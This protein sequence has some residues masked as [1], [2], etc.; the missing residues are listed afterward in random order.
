MSLFNIFFKRKEDIQPEKKSYS[1]HSLIEIL[2][3]KNDE[4]EKSFTSLAMERHN[5]V[6]S[7]IDSIKSKLEVFDNHK[8]GTEEIDPRLLQILLGN[9]KILSTRLH[10]ICATL[11][12]D[13]GEETDSIIRYYKSSHSNLVKTI[14]DT[15][16]NYKKIEYHFHKMIDPVLKDI[17]K[18]A[19]IL[20]SFQND[21][22]NFQRKKQE[23][24]SLENSVKELE[25]TISEKNNISEKKSIMGERLQTLEKEK[26]DTENRLKSLVS[27]G[28]Y[29]NFLKLTDARDSMKRKLEENKMM[30][31][32]YIS[33][34]D[35]A[36][37][38]FLKLVEDGEVIFQQHD[39]LSD[40]IT[41]YTTTE[42]SI[43]LLRDAIIKMD[44]VM[45][46]LE[47]K[48][49]SMKKLRK[50]MDEILNTDI[51]NEIY[52]SK[53]K[54][55]SDLESI[56]NQISMNK[57]VEKF[58]LDEKL[59]K[60]NSDIFSISDALPKINRDLENVSSS[61]DKS[62]QVVVAAFKGIVNEDFSIVE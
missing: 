4:I 30:F 7:M 8:I 31:I 43:P 27:S 29:V 58:E 45:D 57:P 54:L 21:I 24:I 33:P 52:Q 18:I 15:V 47:L 61:I 26:G 39:N 6:S 10:E 44:S 3:K 22:N 50:R 42:E 46:R 11:Q 53:L 35:R 25:K 17:N 36:V 49:D 13:M 2:S 60:T 41:N 5:D 56:E 28:S 51:L 40:L 20:N 37:K 19:V 16:A 23:I 38:K 1:T 12:A 48:E 62:K 55:L 32:N 9:K 59:N 34:L 14:S